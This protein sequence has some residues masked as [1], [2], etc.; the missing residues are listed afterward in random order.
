MPASRPLT[1]AP[2]ARSLAGALLAAALPAVSC[3]QGR[4]PSSADPAEVES[5]QYAVDPSHTQV[6]FGVSHMGFS[7]YYG[8]FSGA[9]GSLELDAKAPAN[10]RFEIHVPV[11][12]V[13]TTSDKLTSELKS[14][15]WLDAAAD[16]EIV[17]KSTAVT[18]LG[19][20]AATVT[21]DLTLHG[22]TRPASFHARL[23]GSGINPLDHKVTVGFDLTGAVRRSDFGVRTYVPLI[24]DMV[25]LTISGAFEKQG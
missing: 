19:P 25:S 4:L 9:S 22:I 10:S 3:A 13:T 1:R 18:P 14:S 23:V 21:G 24:G 12:S 17:F 20:D 7:T 2:L 16:P 8:G 15:T 5:G 6:L 11:R